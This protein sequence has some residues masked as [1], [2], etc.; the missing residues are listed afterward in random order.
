MKSFQSASSASLKGG[1][2]APCSGGEERKRERE[3]GLVL[4]EDVILCRC[5]K[6]GVVDV[7]GAERGRQIA[8]VGEG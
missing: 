4:V 8:D 3:R 1:V 6:W 5:M 7:E 2:A